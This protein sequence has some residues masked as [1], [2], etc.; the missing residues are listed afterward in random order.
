MP[1]GGGEGAW[2]LATTPDTAPVLQVADG[3]EDRLYVLDEAA[4]DVPGAGSRP[5]YPSGVPLPEGE[6]VWESAYYPDVYPV[7][8]T[9]G[10]VDANVP[11]G[12]WPMATT[13]DGRVVASADLVGFAGGRVV[14]Y[15]GDRPFRLEAVVPGGE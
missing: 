13:A 14:R 15:L 12:V 10:L 9:D 7:F 2:F 11:P 8:T 3:A 1:L 5:L 4:V 6:L